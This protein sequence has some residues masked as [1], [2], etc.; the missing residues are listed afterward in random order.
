MFQFVFI[1][2]LLVDLLSTKRLVWRNSGKER[3]E[4]SYFEKRKK[5]HEILFY[6]FFNPN[7]PC[8]LYFK[9][10]RLSSRKG[11]K[12]KA[13]SSR[14]TTTQCLLQ[15]GRSIEPYEDNCLRE[16]DSKIIWTTSLKLD[17]QFL[18]KRFRQISPF[19]V[20]TISS[21]EFWANIVII[22]LAEQTACLK[23]LNGQHF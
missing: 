9:W 15:Q 11:T 14:S 5:K 17:S 4:L 2:A 23:P 13:N 22:V 6:S 21:T 7:L 20:L 1:G 12:D 18:K 10:M 16:L 19:F 8:L 3:K